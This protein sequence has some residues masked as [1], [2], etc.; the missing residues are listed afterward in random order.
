MPYWF[1]LMFSHNQ[2]FVTV[3]TVA[4]QAPL[5]MGYSRQEKWSGLPFPSPGDLPDPGV[6]LMSLALAGE[7]FATET[8]GKPRKT[9]GISNFTSWY[10]SEKIKSRILKRYL[11]VHIE[12]SI[13][14][15]GQEGEATQKSM[16]DKWISQGRVVYTWAIIQP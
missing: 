6:K 13:I 3:Q 1:L 16:K 9:I 8:P 15:N 4:H 2:V 12:N 7:F 5:S 14:S 11:H 10:T